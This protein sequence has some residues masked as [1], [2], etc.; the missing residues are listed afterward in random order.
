MRP[1]IASYVS[2][3][4]GVGGY[5]PDTIVTNH[6]LAQRIDTTDEWIQS[7]VGIK[8]RHIAGEGELT[9][10]LATKAASDAITHAT[11]THD[12][13]KDVID[14]V[15]VATTTPDYTFPATAA[16][17]QHNLGLKPCAAFDIQAVCSGFVYALHT[18]DQ[19]IRLGQAKCALVIGAETMSRI[20][21]WND[22]TTCVLFGDGA[23]AFILKARDAHECTDNHSHIY[24]SRL[25]ADGSGCASLYTTG[26]PSQK[27]L[28]VIAMNGRDVFKAAVVNMANAIDAVLEDHQ[29]QHHAIDWIV[30][31]Q[32][33]QRILDTLAE[34]LKLPTDKVI[35][36][37]AQHANTSAATIPLAFKEAVGDGRLQKGHQIILTS[38]GGGFT[39]GATALRY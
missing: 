33:N 26:G 2:E 37:I 35:S 38:M 22:R 4:I 18:A 1:V 8:Q 10:H 28:G 36:T 19:Y 5:L 21:D 16:L 13:S 39:W 6:D 34:R 27:S 14:L 23:G 32:A 17:V 7:R 30:P 12:F 29:I 31:H 20:L 15:I 25:Y 24:G 3:I 11:L 9:S